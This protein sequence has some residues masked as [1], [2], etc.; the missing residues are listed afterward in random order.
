MGDEE[1]PDVTSLKSEHPPGEPTTEGRPPAVGSAERK[2]GR[3]LA[4]DS[5]I[6]R[7]DHDSLGA[8]YKSKVLTRNTAI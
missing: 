4:F 7:I 3:R 1:T 6:T 2:V 8:R 5:A